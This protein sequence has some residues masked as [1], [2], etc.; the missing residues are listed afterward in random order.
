M[1]IT[2]VISQITVSSAFKKIPKNQSNEKK[3]LK[4]Y[5]NVISYK[6]RE[7]YGEYKRI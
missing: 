1:K 7:E 3:N 6:N 4:L 5:G 2:P